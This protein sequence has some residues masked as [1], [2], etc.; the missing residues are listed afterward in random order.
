MR[1]WFDS[2]RVTEQIR[3]IRFRSVRIRFGSVQILGQFGSLQFLIGSV[4]VAD[5]ISNIGSKSV[6][7]SIMSVRD[8]FRS[9]G[10]DQTCHFWQV[11]LW[12]WMMLLNIPL[13]SN[14]IN[15]LTPLRILWKR[16]FSFHKSQNLNAW[17]K[18]SKRYTLI[19]FLE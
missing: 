2:F 16:S 11:Y 18:R 6:Q 5:S 4:L 19:T 8:W 17:K 10:S 3:S 9:F 13:K 15:H 7:L 1:I 12:S 14:Q